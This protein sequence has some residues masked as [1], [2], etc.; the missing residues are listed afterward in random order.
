MKRSNHCATKGAGEPRSD[1]LPALTSAVSD[2]NYLGF[3]AA[4]QRLSILS[5][6]LRPALT[7]CLSLLRLSWFRAIM[8]SYSLIGLAGGS[9][10][11][12]LVSFSLQAAD[13]PRTPLV[14]ESPKEI[15]GAGDFDGNG[16]VD[17]VIVDKASGKYRLGYQQDSGALTWVDCRPSGLKGVTGMSVA[18]LLG[19]NDALALTSPDDNQFSLI[20]ASSPTA[21]SRP[22]PVLFSAGLGPNTIIAADIGGEGNTPAPDLFVTSIYNSPDPALAS[23]L[24]NDEEEFPSIEDKT[25]AGLAVKGNRLVLGGGQELVC[26]I[27]AEDSGD[28]LKLVDVSS[29]KPV[30]VA[31]VAGLPS[32]SD[33]TFGK[34]RSASARDFVLYKAGSASISAR[35]VEVATGKVA[36]GAGSSYDLGEPVRRV[37]TVP[38][39]QSDRLFVIFGD[40][41]HA[42]LYDFNGTSAP[43]LVKDFTSTAEITGA[44]VTSSG[45]VLFSQPAEGT[46]STRF[47]V[48]KSAEGFAAGPYG[49]LPTLAD[50]DNITIPDIHSRIIANQKVKTEER[51]GVHQHDSRDAGQLCHGADPRRRI[52][53]GQPR[54][55]AGATSRMKARNTRSRSL[56]SGW[57][58]A[59]SP[60][61]SMS[62]SCIRMRR[63]ACAATVPTDRRAINWPMR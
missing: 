46:F 1:V 50:N 9:L 13:S 5:F 34:F 19:A 31:S 58:A 38:G 15:F 57:A 25:L 61:T 28:V 18:K 30:T 16:K 29:G 23:L 10:F 43:K 47:E 7:I 22:V 62:C 44:A 33:Y 35:P 54:E 26:Y 60:G 49:T 56:R 20:D 4:G 40:G 39:A 6:L 8:K 24:R 51:C 63:S 52:P 45:L 14:Y 2:L 12:L 37:I 27:V 36:V 21:P 53:H 42:G 55:R 11:S 41:Q 59:R 48:F 32:G 17:V 3:G